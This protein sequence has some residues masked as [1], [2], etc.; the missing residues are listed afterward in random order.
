LNDQIVVVVVPIG[1]PAW[2]LPGVPSSGAIARCSRQARPAIASAT[3][4]IKMME[5]R[6]ARGYPTPS[7]HPFTL[8][9]GPI[10]FIPFIRGCPIPES[11]LLFSNGN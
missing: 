2:C 7:P 9:P 5:S 3:M 8:L 6:S 1:G 10:R 4:M 11:A